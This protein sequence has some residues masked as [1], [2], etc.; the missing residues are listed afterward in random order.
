MI[1]IKNYFSLK[2]CFIAKVIFSINFLIII[3]IFIF[4]SKKV[5]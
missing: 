3:L 4:E 2:P 5:T 1:N